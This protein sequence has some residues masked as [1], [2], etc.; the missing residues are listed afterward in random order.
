MRDYYVG[1]SVD[2]FSGN[3]PS[4]A[5][6]EEEVRIEIADVVFAPAANHTVYPRARRGGEREEVSLYALWPTMN[7]YS[8]AQRREFVE[9]APDTRRIDISIARRVSPF[10][11]QER[12]ETLYLP[13]TTDQRG[14]RTPYQL[15]KFTFQETRSNVPTSG[16]ANTELFVG[17]DEEGG[18][19]A[20]FCFEER[21]YVASPECWR[22]YEYNDAIEVSYRFK[23]PYL[24]EWRAIDT[25]V[26][27]FVASLDQT[28]TTAP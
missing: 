8:P 2:E 10:T 23:R 11:E 9:N 7:G 22:E 5:V 6:S 4:P 15:T 19:L 16:Y 24:P 14:V 18:L 3:V 28:T 1:P 13:Q 20:L 26:R 12:F 17:A 25:A 21:D 27:D